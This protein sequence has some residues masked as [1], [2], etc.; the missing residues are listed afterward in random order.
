MTVLAV[1]AFVVWV[2]IVA[3]VILD[4]VRRSDLD[5]AATA[6]WIAFVVLLPLV[7]VIAYLITRPSVA[8]GERADVDA[9]EDKVVSDGEERANAIADLARRHAEGELSDEEY[10]RQRRALESGG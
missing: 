3:S 2:F 6:L 7:G 9:F 8:P 1:V 5:G 4:I 10:E